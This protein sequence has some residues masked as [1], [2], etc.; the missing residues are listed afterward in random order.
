MN[1]KGEYL[2]TC[3]NGC[4]ANYHVSNTDLDTKD[5]SIEW[6]CNE[7]NAVWLEHYAFRYWE[8]IND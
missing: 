2:N 1:H 3:P 5:V 4:L 7:C 8:L 6:I